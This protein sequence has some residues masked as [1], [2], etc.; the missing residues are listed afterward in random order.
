MRRVLSHL[1]V[2]F[3]AA[4]VPFAGI[5]AAQ[6]A[7]AASA[8]PSCIACVGGASIKY[9][10]LSGP[11]FFSKKH[12]KYLTGT[13]A[14]SSQYVWT[15]T[16]TATATISTSLSADVKAVTAS[17]GLTYSQSDSYAVAVTIPADKSRYSKLA[18]RSDFNRYYVKKVITLGG[19][20]S[21]YY[22]YVYSPTSNQYL[23]VAYQ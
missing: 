20:S 14:K 7:H 4:L 13:W 6:P 15:H 18:L 12:V 9:Y 5:A 21:N 19:K 10:K 11:V 16:T 23:M 3:L 2:S 8:E 17:L 22:G 1:L